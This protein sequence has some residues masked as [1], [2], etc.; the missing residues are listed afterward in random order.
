MFLVYKYKFTCFQLCLLQIGDTG[1]VWPLLYG[2]TLDR[3][4]LELGIKVG[5]S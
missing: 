4:L 3:E 5:N 2:F 1:Q